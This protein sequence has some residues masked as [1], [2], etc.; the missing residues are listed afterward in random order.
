[1]GSWGILPFE[2]DDALD[3]VWELEDAENFSVLED[4]LAHVAS[5]TDEE[6]VEAAEAEEALAAAEVVAALLGKKL[7]ILPE[8]VSI[9][10]ERNRGKAPDAKLVSLAIK[11]VQRVRTSSELKELWE[12]SDDAEKWEAAM[13][14]LLTRLGA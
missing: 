5:A 4:A 13:D 7:G 1:M 12:E 11:A 8:A 2:N 3:W 14:D 9:F 10:L 6:Y